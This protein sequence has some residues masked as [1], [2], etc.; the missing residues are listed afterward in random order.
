[1]PAKVR[2]VTRPGLQR[3]M[4]VVGA[5]EPN[6]FID[7]HSSEMRIPGL[8]AIGYR[9]FALNSYNAANPVID[10]SVVPDSLQRIGANAFQNRGIRDLSYGSEMD[11]IGQYAFANNGATKST[12]TVPSSSEGTRYRG[13]VML[14]KTGYET[15]WL[16]SDDH[17]DEAIV[18]GEVGSTRPGIVLRFP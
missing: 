14:A 12:D 3:G 5:I 1:M 4:L 15:T 16:R 8:V 11:R 17:A 2:A 13:E 7:A 10:R 18:A 9:P 6:A